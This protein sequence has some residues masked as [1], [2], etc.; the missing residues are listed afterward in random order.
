MNTFKLEIV[1]PDGSIPVRD[2][3]ALDVPA[4]EGR[5][6]VLADHA[7]LVCWVTDGTA[8]ITDSEGSEENW[9][10]RRGTLR[11]TPDLVTL[12]VQS[13]EP[14]ESPSPPDQP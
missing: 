8:G 10:I 3:L 7:P 11:V 4:E 2:V 1:T 6:T 14:P 5:L 12:L 9:T 13:A